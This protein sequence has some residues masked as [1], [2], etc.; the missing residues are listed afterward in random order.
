MF[1][2]TYTVERINA[3]VRNLVDIYGRNFGDQDN[4]WRYYELLGVQWPKHPEEVGK[5]GQ[6]VPLSLGDPN[7]DAL[8]NPVL[9][10]FMQAG[11][12]SCLG[13]HSYAR[14]PNGSLLA[15]GYSFL[16]EHAK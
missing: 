9:E 6:E 11:R 13:C 14:G 15:T 8:M 12:I 3:F 16:L 1:A 4:P 7:R 2:N 10:T 5:A